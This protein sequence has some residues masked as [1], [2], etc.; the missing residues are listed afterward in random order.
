MQTFSL[1]AKDIEKKWYLIDAKGLVLG[2]LAAIV[3]QILNG[4]HKAVYSP[5]LDAGD[6]VI[7]INA[8]KVHLTGDKLNQKQHYWHTNHPGGIKSRSAKEILQGRF[9]ERLIQK[10]VERMMKKAC[11]LRRERIRGLFVYKGGENPHVAQCP[12][13]LDVGAWDRKNLCK[14]GRG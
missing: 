5:H 9:P 4:K 6:R 13:V 14:S 8:E 7:I 3:A 11:P 12:K 1:K 10:A 2:R